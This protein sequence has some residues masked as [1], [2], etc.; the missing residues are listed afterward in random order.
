MHFKT[1]IIMDYLS[2][3]LRIEILWWLKCDT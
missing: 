1:L 3:A 2:M